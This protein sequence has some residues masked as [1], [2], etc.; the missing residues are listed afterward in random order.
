[1]NNSNYNTSKIKKFLKNKNVVTGLCIILAIVVLC[2]A[3]I[4]RVNSATA[5][6]PIPVARETIQPKTKITKEMIDIVEIPGGSLKG[7]YYKNQNNAP[8]YQSD[9]G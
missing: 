2:V 6:I 1:M 8:D 5:P 7:K 9:K 3:Y 4:W